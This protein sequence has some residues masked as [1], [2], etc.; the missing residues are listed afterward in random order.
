MKFSSFPFFIS[1]QLAGAVVIVTTAGSSCT[2]NKPSVKEG[3]PAADASAYRESGAIPVPAGYRRVTAA[4]GSFAA[5]LRRISLKADNTVYL[6][7]GSL[8][9]N[10]SVQFA[11]LDVPVGSKDLQQCADAVMRLRA[12]YLFKSKLHDE[13]VFTDNN[14]KEYRWNGGSDRTAFEKYLETVFGWCGSASL[15][16]QL[17]PVDELFSIE[18]GDVFI[19][20][21]FPG[22]AMLVMDVAVNDNGQKIFLLAQ[23]YMPAQSIHI[24]RN[25]LDEKLSPWFEVNEQRPVITP[26][27]KFQPG[28]LRRW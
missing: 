9:K 24:V 1:I 13:I 10:Q 2:E 5:W 14:K 28:E 19:H 15:E 11:V 7:N 17:N 18:P 27:W 8:K 6:Y 22:H 21:G 25:P 3:K 16:Q 12:E 26:E 23:S 4:S 20:G